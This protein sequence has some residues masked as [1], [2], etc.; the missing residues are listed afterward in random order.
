MRAPDDYQKKLLMDRW[1]KKP[2]SMDDIAH[3]A[4][5]LTNCIACSNKI[6]YLDIVN[7][8]IQRIIFLTINQLANE[9]LMF[10]EQEIQEGYSKFRYTEEVY[11]IFKNITGIDPDSKYDRSILY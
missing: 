10:F 9:P 4:H 7:R 3:N 2:T 5:T 8:A 6:D 11:Q 1:I